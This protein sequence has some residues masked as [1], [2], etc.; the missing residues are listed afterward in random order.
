MAIVTHWLN[1]YSSNN[2]VWL[3]NGTL[4]IILLLQE[5]G[6]HGR[7]IAVP[8]NVCPN[9][10]QAIWYSGNYPHYVDI[11]DDRL[12]ISP[13][14]LEQEIEKVSAVVAVH[15]YGSVCNIKSI[16]QICRRHN[17]FLIED[18]AQALGAH[19]DGQPVGT[20]GDA[21]VFSFGSGKIVDLKYGGAAVSNDASLIQRV[22]S[23]VVTLPD[24][25]EEFKLTISD[26]S[27]LHTFMY[28]RFYPNRVQRYSNLLR[29][30]ALDAKSAYLF[31]APDDLPEKVSDSLK[32]LDVNLSLRLKRALRF[33]E[34]FENAGLMFHWPEDGGI[35]WRFN[36]FLKSGRDNLLRTLLAEGFKVS[37]WYPRIDLFMDAVNTNQKFPVADRI[38][39]EILNLWVNSEVDDN[40]VEQISSR[41]IEYVESNG[42]LKEQPCV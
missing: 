10:V 15:A 13:E 36:L 3:G 1:K 23:F 42:L 7:R 40:Y 26:I 16:V 19:I 18:C 14:A 20:F 30:A 6:L 22:K 34:L 25:S 12:G 31:R 21:A 32:T 28:N 33:R 8:V 11:E 2:C 29:S 24:F 4:A 38:G 5:S 27:A 39:N 35:F 41:I 37:S 9:V 17:K